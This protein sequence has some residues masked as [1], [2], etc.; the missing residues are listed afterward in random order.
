VSDAGA[1]PGWRRLLRTARGLIRQVNAASPVIDHWTLGGGTALML[2][3]EHRE[4]RDIDIFLSDPQQLAFLDPTKRD[5]HFDTQP[6]DHSSDGA[7]FLKFAFS[8]LGEIDFIVAN[9]L[10]ANPT[11]QVPVDGEELSLETPAEIIAKKIYHRGSAIRPRDIFDIAS[12]G[13]AHAD[14]MVRELRNF[15]AEVGETLT[16]L[17]KLN[18]DF[19]NRTILQLAIHP[20]YTAIA[21]TARERAM[22]ILRTV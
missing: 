13:E 11:T 2:R 15:R 3:I 16:A 17:E 1:Q 6:N 7:T 4:S 18:P 20:R 8:E 14:A 9:T 19:V 21:M 22:E 12:C 5:F 10:T